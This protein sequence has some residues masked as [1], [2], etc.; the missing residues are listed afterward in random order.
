[1]QITVNGAAKEIPTGT[2]LAD[3]IRLLGLDRAACAAEVN[4][5]L[6]P[7]REH[8]QTALNEGDTIELVTLVGG[9]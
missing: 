3:L 7:K 4:R 6:V 8:E 2:T 5:S 1:M 9:G